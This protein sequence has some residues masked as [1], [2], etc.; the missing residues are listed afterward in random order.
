MTVTSERQAQAERTKK[1][2]REE[3][4][5]S[6]G[7]SDKDRARDDGAQARGRAARGREQ[8]AYYF[9]GE[10]LKLEGETE[11]RWVLLKIP[12]CDKNGEMMLIELMGRDFYL[13]NP[14]PP[15][16]AHAT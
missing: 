16:S 4:A 7:G 13:K 11:K 14:T 6:W 9:I 12:R 3:K 5:T 1:Q 8:V 10:R 2:K 15:G